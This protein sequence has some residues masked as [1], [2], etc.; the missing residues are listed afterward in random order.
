MVRQSQV[1]FICLL[2]ILRRRDFFSRPVIH[3]ELGW[4]NAQNESN[5]EVAV[6]LCVCKLYEKHNTDA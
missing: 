3:S 1:E 2:V 4:R 5:G 6:A